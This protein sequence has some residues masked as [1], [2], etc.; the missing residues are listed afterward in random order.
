[1]QLTDDEFRAKVLRVLAGQ[2]DGYLT[3]PDASAFVAEGLDDADR[4]EATL[5]ALAA[6]GHAQELE[7]AVPVVDPATQE[8]VV[9]EKGKPVEQIAD[10][11]WVVTDD[12]RT[13]LA[14]APEEG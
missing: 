14:A 8:P 12:G 4:V 3:H 6:E 11:G 9:D 5:L 2:S 13:A 7:D 10:S 1:M